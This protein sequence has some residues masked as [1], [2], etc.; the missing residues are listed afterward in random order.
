VAISCADALLDLPDLPSDN[1]LPRWLAEV[2]GFDM[3]DLRRRWQLAFDIDGPLE[4][5]LLGRRKAPSAI[6]LAPVRDRIEAVRSAAANPRAELVVAGRMSASTLTWLERGARARVRAIVEE[7]GLRAASH[8]ALGALA[9]GVSATTA[10][11]PTSLLGAHLEREG[12]AALGEVLAR[13]GDAAIVDTRVLLAHRLGA[14]EA[15]WP[16]REERFA[17]DLLL[18]ERVRDPWLRD[19]TASAVAAPIPVLLGGHSLVG[20]G[21]RLVVGRGRRTRGAWT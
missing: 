15:R 2:A 13:L 20:P 18:P 19:L 3:R 1:A 5:V 6:D 11:P 4:L 7:R 9:V 10:R 12:A 16:A 8:L 17:S 14:D 21:V